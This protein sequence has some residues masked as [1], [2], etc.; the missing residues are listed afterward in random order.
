MGRDISPISFSLFRWKQKLGQLVRAA[1][2]VMQ[3]QP[4]SHGTNS[5]FCFVEF[6]S[7]DEKYCKVASLVR[8]KERPIW[9]QMNQEWLCTFRFI[10]IQSHLHSWV[11]QMS[12]TSLVEFE[13]KSYAQILHKRII[14]SSVWAKPINIIVSTFGSDFQVEFNYKE[15]KSH[16]IGI[17]CFKYPQELETWIDHVWGWGS[18]TS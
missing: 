5:F 16:E 10:P 13:L 6:D 8:K 15:L 3:V 11:L 7:H 9:H 12:L 17:C 2:D 1:L 14:I 18:L 4:P